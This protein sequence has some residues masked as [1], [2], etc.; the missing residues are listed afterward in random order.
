MVHSQISFINVFYDMDNYK[1]TAKMFFVDRYIRILKQEKFPYGG[2]DR[3]DIK[4]IFKS[5][6]LAYTLRT[7]VYTHKQALL[8]R[9]LDLI[10]Q[11]MDDYEQYILAMDLT[12]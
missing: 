8:N 11:D 12:K 4:C 6:A 9:M 1:P 5:Y 10:V 2:M 7:A 3:E